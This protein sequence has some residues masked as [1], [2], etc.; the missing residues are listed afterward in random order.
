M[1][2]TKI[3]FMVGVSLF[4]GVSFYG[5]APSPSEPGTPRTPAHV[6]AFN[7]GTEYLLALELSLAEWHLR[8]ALSGQEAFP[9]AHSNLAFAAELRWVIDHGHEKEPK[10]FFGVVQTAE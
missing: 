7:R 2:V 1:I 5:P 10:Q 9:E 4:L 3:S 6:E 8:R